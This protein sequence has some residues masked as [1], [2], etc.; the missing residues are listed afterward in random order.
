M[1][2]LLINSSDTLSKLINDLKHVAKKSR[3]SGGTRSV[4]IVDAHDEHNTIEIAI[5]LTH[6]LLTER[7]ER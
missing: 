7:R 2:T 1:A 3:A 6:E 5:D 4:F